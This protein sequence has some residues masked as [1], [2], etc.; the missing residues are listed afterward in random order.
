LYYIILTATEYYW[1]PG[2]LFLLQI[3]YD[4]FL[5]WKVVSWTVWLYT[6][7]TCQ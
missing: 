5:H 7:C 6:Y 1:Y 4:V 2:S 3:Q